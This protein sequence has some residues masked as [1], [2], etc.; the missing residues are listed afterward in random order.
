MSK[1]TVRREIAKRIKQIVVDFE[2]TLPGDVEAATKDAQ[3]RH[4]KDPLLEKL[5]IATGN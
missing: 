3:L 2:P 4:V 5:A 1:L